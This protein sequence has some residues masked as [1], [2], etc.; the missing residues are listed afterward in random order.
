ME[1]NRNFF[2]WWTTPGTPSL[3]TRRG[4]SGVETLVCLY[5]RRLL[6]TG[7]FSRVSRPTFVGLS[8]ELMSEYSR[9]RLLV[10]STRIWGSGVFDV[11]SFAF[12]P[13]WTICRSRLI[14]S[15]VP[16]SCVFVYAIRYHSGPHIYVLCLFQRFKRGR[17]LFRKSGDDLRLNDPSLDIVSLPLPLLF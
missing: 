17:G 3:V 15:R 2:M 11:L 6:V 9:T 8:M 16:S 14:M 12:K 1:D 4:P 5:L 10:G 13:H 7:I